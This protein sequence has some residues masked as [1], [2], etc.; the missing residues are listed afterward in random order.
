M[1]THNESLTRKLAGLLS[2]AALSMGLVSGCASADSRNESDNL[3]AN[4]EFKKV[5]SEFTTEESTALADF[6]MQLFQ[7]LGRED[8]NLLLSGSIFSRS[9]K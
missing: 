6:S 1:H 9:K 8:E 7:N 5:A 3:T 4:M 2:C